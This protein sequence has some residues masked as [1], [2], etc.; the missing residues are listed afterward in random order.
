MTLPMMPWTIASKVSS[1]IIAVS[2]TRMNV[3]PS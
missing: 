1:I 2:M 3:A